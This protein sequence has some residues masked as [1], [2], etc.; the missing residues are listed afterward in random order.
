MAKYSMPE[1]E[2]A[3]N[4]TK[5]MTPLNTRGTSLTRR[6]LIVSSALTLGAIATGVAVTNTP[7]ISND[8]G[9]IGIT[10]TVGMIT[11][12]VRNIGGD[13][14]APEGLMGPGIDP[15][16][17]KP[18]AGDINL[19]GDA[20]MIFYGGL[21]LEGRMTET[22]EKIADSGSKPTVAL[23]A[24]IPEALRIAT[25]DTGESWDPHVWFDVTLW[26]I[27]SETIGSVLVREYPEHTQ[28]FQANTDAY[29]A[30]LDELDAWVIEQAGRLPESQR[31]LITAHDAFGYFGKRYGFEVRGLQGLS[32]ASEAGAGDV[33]DLA[34]F[35]AE[36]EI[37]AMFVESA[38][39]R[40][41]IEA[42]QAAC[43]AQGWN[44]EIGGEL[45]ADAMGEDGTVDGTYIGMVEHN[46]TTIVDALLGDGA[47]STNAEHQ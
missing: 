11:D 34:T 6:H 30:R 17:Y 31:V 8:N 14:V 25:D 21:L 44:V 37:R 42:V 20:D 19:L 1:D 22:F 12:V 43:R 29:L 4:H 47:L 15:H 24:S 5:R 16:S 10:C 46:V 7:A 18:S 2:G 3:H 27:V 32:T 26:R 36:R 38:V 13:V 33:Q 35:I 41:T 9:R 40:A 45:F 23:S 39:P 28:M